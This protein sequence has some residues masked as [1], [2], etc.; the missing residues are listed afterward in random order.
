MNKKTLI[1]F[2]IIL[3]FTGSTYSQ[4]YA[5]QDI[6]LRGEDLISNIEDSQNITIDGKDIR[7]KD[8]ELT[9]GVMFKVQTAN[10]KFNRGLPSW[11]G[12]AEENLDAS[13]KVQMRFY[14][15]GGWQRWVTVGYWDKQLWST[16]GNT[17]FVGGKVDVDYV[18]L[19][20]YV[21]KFQFQVLFKR[22]NVD[23][24]APS[25]RQLNFIASD[26]RTT[27]NADIDYIVN[28]KPPAIFYDTQ[29]IYQYGV[30]PVIGKSICSPSSTAMCLRSLDINVDA[31]DFAVKTKD[32]YWDM[33]GVWPRNVQHAHMH[34]VRGKVTRYRS[35]QEAYEVLK[36]GGRIAMSLGRPLYK[37][38]LIM[39][40]GFDA[41]GTPILHDP[42]SRNGYKRQHNKLDLTK[43]WFNKGGIS[44]TFYLE[45]EE[46]ANEDYS[47]FL[48]DIKI[49]PNPAS[50]YFTIEV[51]EETKINLINNLGQ[52]ILSK[53]ITDYDYIDVSNL[54]SGIYFIQLQ[55]KYGNSNTRK[56]VVK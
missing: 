18:K 19:D 5:D 11:N 49:Y 33:F 22:N 48:N 7:L 55:D 46:L 23:I 53:T 14:S 26:S 41:N 37:G 8:G 10:E 2:I 52:T 44:Y 12:F 34:G 21:T 13:F 32:Q 43:S 35:W 20:A 1:S 42:G 38:H 39:L 47:G 27:A 45:N 30:D 54:N 25:I 31:Y 36:N 4:Q 15:F 40:A 6:T 3:L 51:V 16:Y 9:G 17:T 24:P 56:I 29:F 50:E 28:Q